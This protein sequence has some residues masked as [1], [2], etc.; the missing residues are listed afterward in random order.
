MGVTDMN[1]LL[2]ILAAIVITPAA[3]AQNQFKLDGFSLDS[4]GLYSHFHSNSKLYKMDFQSDYQTVTDVKTGSLK[5]RVERSA[6]KVTSLYKNDDEGDSLF[7]FDNEGKVRSATNCSGE[8]TDSTILGGAFAVRDGDLRCRT[9]TKAA[10]KKALD[11]VASYGKSWTE[12]NE[13]SLECKSQFD[14]MKELFNDTDYIKQSNDDRSY[15]ESQYK[16]KGFISF[17]KFRVNQKTGPLID[18]N[19]GNPFLAIT[20]FT[21]MCAKYFPNNSN[22]TRGFAN[23]IFNNEPKNNNRPKAK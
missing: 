7:R 4:S 22:S 8:I 1:K 16:S 12:T 18:A 11:A 14:K 6:N 2:L 9:A 3:F 10:C 5:Y 19:T 20:G 15:V 23:A 13:I 17:E 21:S